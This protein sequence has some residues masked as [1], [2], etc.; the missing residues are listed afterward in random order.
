MVLTNGRPSCGLFHK[1]R[2]HVNTS[3]HVSL[4]VEHY[5]ILFRFF[6][7]I[8]NLIQMKCEL[9]NGPFWDILRVYG[10]GMFQTSH[11]TLKPKGNITTKLFPFIDT[12]IDILNNQKI[13]F[14]KRFSRDPVLATRGP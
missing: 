10:V 5:W 13:A 4:V 7:A 14:G 6:T 2:T 8:I 12:L 3:R 1:Q 9:F 11:K